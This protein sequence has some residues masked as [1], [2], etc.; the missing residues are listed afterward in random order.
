MRSEG[1][2]ASYLPTIFTQ[3]IYY[4]KFNGLFLCLPLKKHLE[5]K[6]TDKDDCTL[7]F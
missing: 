4:L 1:N 3:D 5:K 7:F 6:Q 2:D